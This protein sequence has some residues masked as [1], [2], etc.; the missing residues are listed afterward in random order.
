MYKSNLEHI[1]DFCNIN[2]TVPSE[3]SSNQTFN[4]ANQDPLDIGSQR[5][6]YGLILGFDI[7]P[8]EDIIGMVCSD[9]RIIFWQLGEKRDYTISE[10]RFDKKFEG[11]IWF[12][13]GPN[14]WVTP[15]VNH[16]MN[17]YTCNTHSKYPVQLK[18][19]IKAH[20][21]PLTGCLPLL[22]GGSFATSSLDGKIKIWDSED[23]KLISEMKSQIDENG[24]RGIIYTRRFGGMLLSTGFHNTILV[25]SPDSSL[26]KS[27]IGKLEGHSAV[28]VD[29]Q[30]LEAC[31]NCVSVDE[32]R[33]IRVWDI[34]S[35]QAIQVIKGEDQA[36]ATVVNSLVIIPKFDKFVIGGKRLL[37]YD[38][39]YAKKNIKNFNEEIV[40]LFCHFN[41]Y[42]RVFVVV[43]KIDV[44]LYDG[45]SGRLKK[46]FNK[47]GNDQG[48]NEFTTYSCASRDRKFF[49]GNNS[50]LVRLVNAYNGDT[51]ETIEEEAKVKDHI[52]GN[53]KA[54][55]IQLSLFNRRLHKLFTWRMKSF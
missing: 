26:Y 2:K 44:R 34:R 19:Q 24:I 45:M 13:K 53:M 43:T 39:N 6:I 50:G 28:I 5:P 25:W 41:A 10:E 21:R 36:F 1:K 48:S 55:V 38:N 37:L 9:R 29:I 52:L 11:T 46:V 16:V 18:H 47:F 32:M 23:F 14:V 15:F 54:N 27:F 42:H 31:P 7:D 4:L 35:F 22:S 20:S 17:I 12:L 30:F 51:I 3:R 49:L 8:R 33:C 40:P